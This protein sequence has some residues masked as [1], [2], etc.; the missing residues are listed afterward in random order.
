MPAGGSHLKR[1]FYVLLPFDLGKIQVISAER[2][3][4]R[5]FQRLKQRFSAEMRQKLAH[6]FNAEN[7]NALGEGCIRRVIKGDEKALYPRASGGKRHRQS[8]AH[9]AKLTRK[10][11]LSE[12]SAVIRGLLYCARCGQNSQQHR[13][14]V[15][16]A[17]L[18]RVRRGKVYRQT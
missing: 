5:R 16:R 13:Q 6:G 1:A 7:L 17:A 14:I 3:K 18:F 15:G 2:G 11:Q 10:P 4:L 12:E 8:A 9:G